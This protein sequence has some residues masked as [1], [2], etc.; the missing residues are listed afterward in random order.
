MR[1]GTTTAMTKN[2]VSAKLRRAKKKA[3]KLEAEEKKAEESFL[4]ADLQKELGGYVRLIFFFVANLMLKWRIGSTG[5][6]DFANF[7][8]TSRSS[9]P[10]FFVFHP[11]LSLLFLF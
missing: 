9:I 1:S 3:A 4:S 11:C 2:S 8:T 7:F 10:R 5:S 6:L